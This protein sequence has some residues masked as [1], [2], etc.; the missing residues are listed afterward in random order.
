LRLR[1]FLEELSFGGCEK[2]GA[3]KRVLI[4]DKELIREEEVV[5]R[6]EERNL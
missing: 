3:R 6:R 4:G 1:G 2:L 5:R